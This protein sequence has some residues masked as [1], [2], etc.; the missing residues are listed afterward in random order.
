MGVF[1]KQRAEASRLA[2]AQETNDEKEI[3]LVVIFKGLFF[4]FEWNICLEAHIPDVGRE[5]SY[6]AGTQAEFDLH[7]GLTF[8][9]LQELP[10]SVG[11]K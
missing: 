9:A 7:R 4:F 2:R 5:H 8:G 6:R 1:A 11:L 3:T 10:I